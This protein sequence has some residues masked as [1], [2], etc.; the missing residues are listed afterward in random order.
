MKHLLSLL[1]LI[2]INSI[3]WS[4]VATVQDSDGWTNVR[5][6]PNGNSRIINRI[7]EGEVYWYAFDDEGS[8]SNWSEIY[9]LTDSTD[10]YFSMGNYSI[11]YIHRSRLLELDSIDQYKGKEFQIEFSIS[12]FDTT[13]KD[14]TYHYYSE[15]KSPIS[16]NG[17][18]IWGTD[19]GFPYNQLDSVMVSI[20]N[21]SF[22]VNPILHENLFNISDEYRVYHWKN[23]WIVYQLN[24]DGA[25]T[26]ESVWV[27]KNDRLHQVLVGS[28]L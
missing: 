3:T 23:T 15:G 24:S 8:D 19:G 21:T 4:Q 20:G 22:M 10:Y 2:S 17:K 1:T 28:I 26:Y 5:E 9:Y 13:G 7:H 12:P 6:K 27:F 16:I 18:V 11:G 14:I 25:G